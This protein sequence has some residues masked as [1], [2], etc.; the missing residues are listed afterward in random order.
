MLMRGIHR[1]L[2]W[3]TDYDSQFCDP[4]THW[5]EL[6]WHVRKFPD[7]LWWLIT[8]NRWITPGMLVPYGLAWLVPEVEEEFGRTKYLSVCFPLPFYWRDYC[9]QR[10]RET[11]G[12]AV[13]YWAVGYRGPKLRWIPDYGFCSWMEQPEVYHER[14]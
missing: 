6:K 12:R 8:V 3:Y 7:F 14:V 10:D 11:W 1:W 5:D 9:Y 4:W 13:F 2:R